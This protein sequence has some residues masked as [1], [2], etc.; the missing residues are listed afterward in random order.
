M[1]SILDVL[2]NGVLFVLY[3]VMDQCKNMNCDETCEISTTDVF[4]FYTTFCV[5]T[6]G[7]LKVRVKE[8]IRCEGQ[9]LSYCVEILDGDCLKVFLAL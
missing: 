7:L 8:G 5:C 3:T 1:Y 6:Q 4:P 9:A 2:T